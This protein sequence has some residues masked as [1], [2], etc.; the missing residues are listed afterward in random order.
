MTAQVLHIDLIKLAAE[1][2]SDQRARLA[3]AASELVEI[4]GVVSA[5]IIEGS[6][7]SDFDIAVWF[8]LREFLALEPFGT[9]PRYSRFLQ[10][11]VAPMVQ[12]FAGADVA[13]EEAIAARDGPA[14]CL[15]LM[16]PEE[17]YDFEV[18]EALS[19]WAEGARAAGSAIGLAVGEKQIY[20]G[21]A[22]VFGASEQASRPDV[23]P[24]RGTLVAGEGRTLT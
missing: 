23:E 11:E 21:A 5:G 9:D 16:G 20:R 13:L 8:A 18:R 19:T 7:E 2:G 10:G 1:T 22:L 15:A 6:E 4:D 17:A 14:A 3:E 12:G 24:F